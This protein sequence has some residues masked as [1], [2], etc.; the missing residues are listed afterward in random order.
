MS[1]ET[2]QYVHQLNASNPSGADRLKDGD[3]HLRMIKA[4]LLNTFP[5][6]KGPLDASVTHTLLNSIA[7]LLV[8]VGL[9]G[10]WSGPEDT[11]PTGWAICDGRTVTASDGSR[12]FA[13]PNFTDRAATG[14]NP[15]GSRPVGTAFGSFATTITTDPGGAHTHTASTSASGAHSHGGSTGPTG[16][17]VAQL[18]SHN[19]HTAVL[20]TSATALNASPQSP[21]AH[22]GTYG[23][24]PQ[25]ILTGGSGAWAGPSETVGSGA[26]HAHSI[27]TDGSHTHPVTVDGA[28]A[29]SHAATINVAQ[30]SL[31]LYYIMK[32]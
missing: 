15:A 7:A 9:I 22:Q 23:S 13:T 12:S 16:L 24:N 18:P 8:P 29:H 3:D 21:V 11:V 14:A 2:A 31:A 19:H 25:Y 6:I 4:A 1:L 27:A 10:L 32:I 5:G 30:P 28:A 20:A 17:S 26:G